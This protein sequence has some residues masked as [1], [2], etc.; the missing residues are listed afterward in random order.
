MDLWPLICFSVDGDPGNY[1]SIV[2]SLVTES[3]NLRQCNHMFPNADGT[4]GNF[5]SNVDKVNSVYGGWRLRADRL[6]VVNGQY[7]PWRSASLSSRWAPLFRST[8][9]QQL[10][11]V[12]GGH[13]C[14]DWDLHGFV[15]NPDIKR[16]VDIG[17]GQV[18][19]WVNDWYSSHPGVK[20]KMP[21][22]VD[23]WDGVSQALKT[24]AHM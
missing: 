9:L 13:H 19:G 10:E 7:D 1:S 2:S 18:K 8:P 23:L 21:Q 6:F 12:E 16:V 4:P 3:Y 15:E 20:N 14:W 24:K 5:T 11:V 22:K 17:I